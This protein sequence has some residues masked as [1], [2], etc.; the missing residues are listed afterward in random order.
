MMSPIAN[1]FSLIKEYPTMVQLAS[2]LPFL[3]TKVIKYI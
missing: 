3:V 2:D 1:V